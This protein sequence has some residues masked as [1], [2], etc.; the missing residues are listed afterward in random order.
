MLRCSGK[1]VQYIP[2]GRQFVIRALIEMQRQL[3]VCI[4]GIAADRAAYQFDLLVAQIDIIAVVKICQVQIIQLGDALSHIDG[5]D[6][7]SVVIPGCMT[8]P[9]VAIF[10]RA[11]IITGIRE[12]AVAA[13]LQRATVQQIPEGIAGADQPIRTVKAF[14]G[15]IDTLCPFGPAA[16]ADSSIVQC[17]ETLT[18]RFIEG[19]FHRLRQ[20]RVLFVRCCNLR[21]RRLVPVVCITWIKLQ[22]IFITVRDLIRI[23]DLKFDRRVGI[24]AGFLK[25]TVLL[26][27]VLIHFVLLIHRQGNSN[28][29]CAI[30]AIIIVDR[31]AC[32]FNIR[33]LDLDGFEVRHVS[34]GQRTNAGNAVLNYNLLDSIFFLIPIRLCKT[35]HIGLSARVGIIGNGTFTANGEGIAIDLIPN[36]SAGLY[37]GCVLVVICYAVLLRRNGNSRCSCRP[38]I[39]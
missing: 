5:C 31:A 28:G 22:H 38:A 23:A 2:A 37:I 25:P 39:T 35:Q 1:I 9:E 12:R 7:S 19:R 27:P 3:A 32:Q 14:K 6:E 36:R 21:D 13:Q 16:L 30:I 11:G 18:N 26:Q 33:T 24:L 8:K 34:N 17:L 4:A 20:G 15:N 10:G 29:Q